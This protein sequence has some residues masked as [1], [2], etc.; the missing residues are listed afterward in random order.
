VTGGSDEGLVCIASYNPD[1]DPSKLPATSSSGGLFSSLLGRDAEPAPS[2]EGSMNTKIE[3]RAITETDLTDGKCKA[4]L[5]LFARGTTESGNMGI[6]VGPSLQRGLGSSK[7]AYQGVD[8]EAT[9]RELRTAQVQISSLFMSQICW[10]S[11]H[12][13]VWI[14]TTSDNE[15]SAFWLIFHVLFQISWFDKEASTDKPII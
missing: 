10:N 4:N 7:W 1:F 13:I 9:V 8:Y 2:L 12:Y 11:R 5:L 3:K 15:C 6:T 14:R